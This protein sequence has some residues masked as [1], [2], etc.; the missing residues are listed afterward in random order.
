MQL[1]QKGDNAIAY[2]W[3]REQ[4]KFISEKCQ[5]LNYF[6]EKRQY[7]VKTKNGEFLYHDRHIRKK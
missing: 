5:I 2:R 4:Q 1:Y 3:S 6:P 7:H